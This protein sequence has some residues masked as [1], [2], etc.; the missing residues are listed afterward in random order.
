MHNERIK[1]LATALN[2]LGVG[3]LLA[4]IVVPMVVNGQGGVLG[5]YVLA[6]LSFGVAQIVLGELE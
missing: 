3:A 1:L 4:G 2:N 5:C 6:L